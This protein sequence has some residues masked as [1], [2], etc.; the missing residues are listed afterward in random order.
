MSSKPNTNPEPQ[1]ALL[2]AA[3]LDFVHAESALGAPVAE[4]SDADLRLRL[5]ALVGEA[6]L[7]DP[8]R[9]LALRRAAAQAGALGSLAAKAAPAELDGL[10]VASLNTGARQ[11]RA[12][13]QLRSLP[14]LAA[15][16]A[17]DAAVARIVIGDAAGSVRAP[18][19][20]DRLVEESLADPAKANTRSMA[21]RLGRQAAPDELAER[22]ES[23]LNGGAAERDAAADEPIGARAVAGALLSMGLAVALV[24]TIGLRANRKAPGTSAEPGTAAPS[25]IASTDAE[26]QGRIAKVQLEVIMLDEDNLSDDDR[27]MLRFLGGAL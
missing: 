1:G 27:N 11:D 17:L 16:A 9:L 18:G 23:H 25:E 22:V 5:R 4:L 2:P 26:S 10:V 6:E 7:G 3:W 20:L 12:I 19:V 24:V 15:P 8:E 14:A 13:D 21:A